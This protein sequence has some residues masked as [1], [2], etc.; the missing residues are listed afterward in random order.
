[1]NRRELR[2]WLASADNPVARGARRLFRAANQTRARVRSG[3][4]AAEMDRIVARAND[5]TIGSGLPPRSRG[6]VDG[7][8]L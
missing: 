3:S 4:V 8:T 1:M 6:S 2:H 5:P 7:G